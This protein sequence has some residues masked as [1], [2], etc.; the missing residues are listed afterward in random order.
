MKG[1]EEPKKEEVVAKKDYWKHENQLN[2]G[3]RSN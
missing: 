3:Y 1:K 2:Y